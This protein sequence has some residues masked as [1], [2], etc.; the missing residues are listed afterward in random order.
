M[1]RSE[2]FFSN[3]FSLKRRKALVGTKFSKFSS[4]SKAIFNIILKFQPF[5]SI[6]FSILIVVPLA[7]SVIKGIEKL[8]YQ[9]YLY[10][11]GVLGSIEYVD[12]LPL[13]PLDKEFSQLNK[14]VSRLLFDPLFTTDTEGNIRG[15]L[16]DTYE[17]N[18]NATKFT[19]K[20]KDRK[21]NFGDKVTAKDV[22]DTFNTIK[23]QGN[24]G[25]Y[26]PA[27]E[28]VDIVAIDENTVA[29]TILP[30]NETT[31]ATPNVAFY[32]TLSWP[33]LPSKYLNG[34]YAKL[35]LSDLGRKSPSD[36]DW[37][38]EAIT[39]KY[40]LLKNNTV[41]K[42]L[43]LE[44]YKSYQEMEMALNAG[45][46]NGYSSLEK[47][48]ERPYTTIYQYTLPRQ[49]Y[50][51]YFNFG[52]NGSNFLRDPNV[53]KA[54][55]YAIERNEIA[56]DVGVARQSVISTN[57]WAFN[58]AINTYS[59]NI[60][61]AN[62][63]LDDAGYA[64]NGVYRKQNDKELGFT[65]SVP[66]IASRVQQ[67]R[68][69]KNQLQNI[70]INVTIKSIQDMQYVNNALRT[71]IFY[72][73]VVLTKN[74]EAMIFSVDSGL[75]PD[76]FSQWHSSNI[77]DLSKNQI[78]LNFSSYS[79]FRVDEFLRKGRSQIDQNARKQTYSQFM[80]VFYEDAPVVTLYNPYLFY[81]T[82]KKVQSVDFTNT[83]KI[84]D[85]FTNFK[86]WKF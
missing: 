10:S 62:K 43:K 72:N 59:L 85:R 34:D 84:E 38:L 33:I 11:E 75:D 20:L 82:S 70:G 5:S 32:E 60:D 80:K 35:V 30:P 54:I 77:P 1:S 18:D 53:R 6:A 29:F 41:N 81:V 52:E 23:K 56:G 71:N 47:P 74:F 50:S 78:G 48:I 26:H 22:V 64:K 83:I 67:A 44:F 57:S 66:N 9:D 37:S 4:Y 31:A 12:P 49:T 46:I 8:P 21:W 28:G 15:L 42:K 61:A 79:N 36:T 63:I 55:S 27:V 7:F 69:I 51:L 17:V 45:F 76:K 24:G 39:N 3:L 68:I 25:L 58:P 40:V 13:I 14:E 65:L 73:S 19:I 16:G 2:S 86:D